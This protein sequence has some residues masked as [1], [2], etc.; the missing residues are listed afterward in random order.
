M[1]DHHP[2]AR[3]RIRLGL[4][5][6]THIVICCLS[7][8]YVAASQYPNAFNPTEFHIFYD[9]SRWYVAAAAVA[10][11]A[12]V[13]YFL[14]R[15]DFSI[16]YFIGFYLYTMVLGYLW[17]NCFTDLNYDHLSAALSAAASTVAFLV[18]ALLIVAPI[19]Q[20]FVLSAPALDRL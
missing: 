5:I 13:S 1:T 20:T 14:L 11:F 7:L 19:R 17:L 16:G 12:L 10:A 8:I 9:P 2:R 6:A 4:L 15:C 3:A 18:P